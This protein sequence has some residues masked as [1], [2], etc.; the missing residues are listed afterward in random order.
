M[1]ETRELLTSYFR[2]G[3]A[4]TGARSTLPSHL[5]RAAPIGK[6]IILGCGKAA[7]EMAEV[8]V[9][10][11]SG[12][13]SGCVVTRHGHGVGRPIPG[14]EVLEARTRSRIVRAFRLASDCWSWQRARGRKTASY[15]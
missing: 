2:A 9:D 14:I 6:T 8:A 15:S 12:P 7:A 13:I 4:A 1:S 10:H 5:P 3:I 11:L